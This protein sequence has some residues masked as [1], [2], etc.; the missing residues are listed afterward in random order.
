MASRREIS[1]E[2]G[3]PSDNIKYIDSDKSEQYS[4]PER[5]TASTGY[6]TI[7]TKNSEKPTANINMVRIQASSCSKKKGTEMSSATLPARHIQQ[8]D[9]APKVISP[10]YSNQL[11]AEEHNAVLQ[12][13]QQ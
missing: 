3:K 4:R 7:E 8:E 13:F 2:D 12:Y 6:C 11:L 1:Q 10:I 9:A 5:S